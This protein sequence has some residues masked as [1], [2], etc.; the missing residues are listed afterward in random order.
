MKF[1]ERLQKRAAELD[2]KQTDISK[3]LGIPKTTLS[4][5][6][7]GT[8]EPDLETLKLLATALDTTASFLLGEEQENQKKI[9]ENEE[10]KSQTSPSAE[11]FFAHLG[12]TNPEHIASLLNIM[13]LMKTDSESSNPPTQDY[14][15]KE[16]IIKHA[17]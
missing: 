12:I 9:Q 6:F 13:D 16:S 14:L 8:R 1:H 17:N 5:Y 4:G 11:E 7:R 3:K 2:M 10:K 15:K